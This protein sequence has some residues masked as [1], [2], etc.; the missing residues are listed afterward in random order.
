MSRG[1]FMTGEA[2]AILIVE[3]DSDALVLLRRAFRKAGVSAP[4]HVVTDGDTAIAY[5]AG[6]GKCADRTAYPLPIMILLDLKLPKR[7][8]LEILEW[9]H[10]QPDLR[11]I[12]VIVVTSSDEETDRR[13][14]AELGA[15]HYE[16]K[17]VDSGTLLRLA[18]KVR[19]YTGLRERRPDNRTAG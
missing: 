6:E 5:L 17:L 15:H 3:D 11:D 19:R 8:G 9:K 13:R 18:R 10:R 2:P 7:S 16:V 14:A 4:I 12:P 1:E